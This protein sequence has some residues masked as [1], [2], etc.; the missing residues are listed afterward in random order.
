MVPSPENRCD[1]SIS[2]RAC[3]AHR[4]LCYAQAS[5]YELRGGAPLRG[6]VQARRTFH[7]VAR[8]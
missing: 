5:G 1:F 7:L 8:R 4:R 3:Q 2:I 6:L